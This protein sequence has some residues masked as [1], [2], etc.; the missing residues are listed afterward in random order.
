MAGWLRRGLAGLG[1]AMEK[2]GFEMM[3]ADLEEKKAVRLAELNASFR[4]EEQAT[5]ITARER[6]ERDIRQSF[7][8]QQQERGFAQ[9]QTMETDVRQPF[10]REER[11]AREQAQE[12]LERDV[13][14]PHAERMQKTLLEAQAEQHRLNREVQRAGQGIQARQVKVMEQ[15]A[16]LDRQIKQI[17]IDNANEVQRL[18]QQ[19]TQETDPQK[20]AQ[21]VETVQLLTGKDNDNY[22]PVPLKDE[23]GNI[24]GYE[25]FDKK[26]GAFVER[27]RQPSPGDIEG[28]RQRRQNPAAIQ[29]FDSIYGQGA[30]ARV[31]GG[32]GA[33]AVSTGG[34]ASQATLGASEFNP[35]YWVK[36]RSTGRFGGIRY[37]NIRTN[38]YI[39]E[40]EYERMASG[41]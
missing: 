17:Q 30:A 32:A 34:A 41:R 13:R 18:R 26:R 16:D 36:E 23:M 19:Y 14:Q 38:Q 10:Q 12:R 31:L 28:L 27:P 21:I 22:L 11:E 1:G 5:D 35:E 37:R 4:R 39:T 33:P 2:S 25:I 9:Q 3:R 15:G 20:K 6:M 40:Q 29:R 8:Q 7:Q 24:T